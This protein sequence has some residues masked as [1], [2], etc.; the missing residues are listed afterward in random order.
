MFLYP[1][2]SK[3]WHAFWPVFIPVLWFEQWKGSLKRD[4]THMERSCSPSYICWGQRFRSWGQGAAA[5]NAGPAFFFYSFL[6][7]QM[8]L[9]YLAINS[10]KLPYIHNWGHFPPCERQER[11][12]LT[13]L[14]INWVLTFLSSPILG[15]P[16]LE[17]YMTQGAPLLSLPDHSGSW[18][19]EEAHGVLGRVHITL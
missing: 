3:S 18:N 9:S 19:S 6:K 16:E 12:P 10:C 5:T 8:D 17:V 1:L 13:V 14:I 4:K 7:L 15:P 11:L 2:E